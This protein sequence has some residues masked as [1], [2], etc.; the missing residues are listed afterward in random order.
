MMFS[1]AAQHKHFQCAMTQY[2]F[3]KW[4][5]HNEKPVS[6]RILAENNSVGWC[7]QHH[8]LRIGH[9]L[10]SK[11]LNLDMSWVCLGGKQPRSS[12]KGVMWKCLSDKLRVH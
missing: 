11:L 6:H 3:L 4:Q 2:F 12:G 10:G 1:Y 7:W 9:F 5:K 8:S